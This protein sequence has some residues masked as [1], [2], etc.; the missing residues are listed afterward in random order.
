[1]VIKCVQEVLYVSVVIIEGKRRRRGGGG[2]SLGA[3]QHPVQPT[4]LVTKDP[5]AGTCQPQ[6]KGP[7]SGHFMPISGAKWDFSFL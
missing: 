7:S 4:P 1:M 3:P 2:G 6:I 5:S